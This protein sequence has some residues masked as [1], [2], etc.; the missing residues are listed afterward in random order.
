MNYPDNK[1]E[2]TKSFP[3]APENKSI[4]K[5]NYNDYMNKIKHMNYTKARILICDWSDKKNFLFHYGMLKVYVGHGKVVDKFHEITS[6]KQSKW[7]EKY[8]NFNTQNEQRLKMILKK[9]SSNT[10]KRIL[11]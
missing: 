3:F 5:Q 8:I 1:K 9:T 6:F 4:P 7:A 2:K 10:Q 11:W